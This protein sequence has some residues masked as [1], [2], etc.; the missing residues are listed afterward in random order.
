MK[1]YFDKVLKVCI[2]QARKNECNLN[3]FDLMYETSLAYSELKEIIDKL[4]LNNELEVINIKTYKFIG[5]IN[6]NFE[7]TANK[8]SDLPKSAKSSRED[9]SLADRRAYLEKRRQELIARMQA[10]MQKDDDSDETDT[11]TQAIK[12]CVDEEEVTVNVRENFNEIDEDE[13]RYKALKLCIEKGQV[14]VSMFQ[15]AFPIGYLRSCKLVDWMEDMGYISAAEGIK[16]RKVLIAL[17]EFNK[18]FNKS[19]CEEV[20]FNETEE[21]NED[22]ELDKKFAEYEKYLQGELNG[23]DETEECED[24][25]E[26]LEK[27]GQEGLI[28]FLKELLREGRANKPWEEIPEHPSWD[29]DND[30]MRFC[31]E[32]LI[33]IVNS[34]K[35]TGRQGALKKAKVILEEARKTR[36][37]K[38]IEVYECIIFELQNMSNYYY[39]KIRSQLS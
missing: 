10:E 33:E 31:A 39:I 21:D 7:E 2:E 11:Y 6:R 35:R 20:L 34:D 3:V 14:S 26:N 32:K 27:N 9:D 17:D 1:N 12:K 25:F 4:V 22:D 24:C 15:R 19:N 36:S 37:K 16:S 30:F 23:L 38:M 29:N 8:K 28:E 18:I 5:D 13:L